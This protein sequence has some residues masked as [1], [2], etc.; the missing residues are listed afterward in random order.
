MIVELKRKTRMAGTF[1]TFQHSTG[2]KVI[3]IEG[4]CFLVS[5]KQWL[6]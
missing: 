4:L 5:L 1:R 3:F 2:T 6:A